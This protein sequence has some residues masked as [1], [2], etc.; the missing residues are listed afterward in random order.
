[1]QLEGLR[2][3]MIEQFKIVLEDW[4]PKDASFAIATEG[5]YLFI[6]Q[7]TS[8][9]HLKMNEKVHPESLAAK[10]LSTRRKA[11]IQEDSSMFGIP[12]NVIGYPIKIDQQDAALIVVFPLNDPTEK[13]EPYQFLTGRQEDDWTPVPI[14]QISYFESLQKRTWF[15]CN[16]EKFKTMIT[17]KELQTKLPASFLRIHRSYIINIYF[18]KRIS[19]DLTS[20]FVIELKNG[21][22]LP[23]SQSYLSNLRKILGF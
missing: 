8:H 20:N 22:Q 1:M 21:I 13:K 2:Q 16:E 7:G 10:V 18:I 12:S 19:K 15:Y 14:D 9:L 5:R 3:E 11:E 4:I 17:L 23:V 6:K